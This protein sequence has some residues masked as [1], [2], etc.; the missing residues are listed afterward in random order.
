MTMIVDVKAVFGAFVAHGV[1]V[2]KAVTT[3]GAEG[4]E[5]SRKAPRQGKLRCQRGP[6]K[7]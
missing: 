4:V 1:R 3:V 2:I 7:A 6:N 5:G